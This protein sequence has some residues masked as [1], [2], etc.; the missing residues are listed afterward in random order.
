LI[1]NGDIIDNH[2]AR[3]QAPHRRVIDLIGQVSCRQNVIWVRGN[4][5]DGYIPKGMDKV[6]F[7]SRHNIQQRLLIFHGDNF[8]EIMPRSLAFI[9]AFKM[10]HDLRVKLG[11][12]PVH[13]AQ[14]A[15]KW[16]VLYN[17]LRRNVMINAANCAV[18]NGYEAVT[19]GHTHYAEDT[20]IKG[21]RY[22]NTGAW[23]ELP[24]FYLLVMD[25][26]IILKKIED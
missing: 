14:Y 22:I 23:T 11:A 13:V 1:L 3:L 26:A 18:E 17:V 21:I 6:R 10:M 20:V 12:K 7:K 2:Y 4:H 25:N 19:C 15:K 5:D 24:V 9:K 8:D 16:A